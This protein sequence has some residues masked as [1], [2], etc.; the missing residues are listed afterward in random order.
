M[1]AHSGLIRCCHGNATFAEE[2][3]MSV[4]VY[5]CMVDERLHIVVAGVQILPANTL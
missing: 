4:Y 5:T 3:G 1:Y 2:E